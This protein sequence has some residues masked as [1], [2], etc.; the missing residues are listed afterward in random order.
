MLLEKG[1]VE[2]SKTKTGVRVT[3][4]QGSVVNGKQTVSKEPHEEEENT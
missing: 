3:T 1:Y 2:N 4:I